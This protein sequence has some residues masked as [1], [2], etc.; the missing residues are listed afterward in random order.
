MKLPSLKKAQLPKAP[1]LTKLLGPS[2]I[3]LGL[4][5]GSGEIILW[6][7]LASKYG[8]GLIWGALIGITLQFFLNM[9]IARYTLVTGESIFVGF[10]R[11]FGRIA[12]IWFI[13]AT[14]VPWMWPGIAAASAN[15]IASLLHIPYSNILPISL[16]IAIGIILTAGKVVYKTQETFQR[17]AILIGVPFIFILAIICAKQ[18]DWQMLFAGVVGQGEGFRFFPEGLSFATFLGALAYAG[19]GGTLNLTQSLYVKEKGYGMGSFSGR[20]TSLVSGKKESVQ[21]TGTTFNQTDENVNRFSTWWKNI[22][23]EHGIVFWTTGAITMLLLSL[24]SYSTLYGEPG[25]PSGVGFVI[26]EAHAIGEKLFP[27]AGVLFLAISSLMLFFT[28][29]GVLASTSRIMS[30]NFI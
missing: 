15:M 3:L 12:P 21:L 10:S 5:L 17:A 6:P 30:E 26:F 20:I 1:P 13:F 18:A 16:L 19:A 29:F 27:I 23:L 24:L 14:L 25:I 8:L 2:F 22:N 4:G 28:Q 7:F 9:E 11:K